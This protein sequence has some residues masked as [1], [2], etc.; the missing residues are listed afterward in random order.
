MNGLVFD[1][2]GVLI[3]AGD[4]VRRTCPCCNEKMAEGIVSLRQDQE[5]NGLV[6]RDFVKKEDTPLHMIESKTMLPTI[7]EVIENGV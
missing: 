2:N 3:K 5:F 6:L 4:K 1:K 7:L